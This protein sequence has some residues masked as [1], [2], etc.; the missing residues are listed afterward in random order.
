MDPTVALSLGARGQVSNLCVLSCK[1]LLWSMRVPGASA[2]WG[3]DVD[4]T[5]W[6]KGNLTGS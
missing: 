6:G 1:C 3:P 4:A 5:A 2:C